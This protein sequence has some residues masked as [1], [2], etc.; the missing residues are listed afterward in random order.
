MNLSRESLWQ[1]L[2][3]L[4]EIPAP[5]APR[6]RRRIGLME[7][8]LMLPVKLFFVAAIFYSF[9]YSPWVRQISNET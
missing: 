5:D 8:N 7:R 1:R 4:F 3:V 6:A 9:N 2:P